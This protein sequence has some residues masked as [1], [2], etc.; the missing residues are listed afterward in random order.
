MGH[1]KETEKDES[2]TDQD[3]TI[4]EKVDVNKYQLYCDNGTQEMSRSFNRLK[5]GR[6][7]I[8]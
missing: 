7:I 4:P 1:R 8:F 5:E 2:T 6:V 3:I